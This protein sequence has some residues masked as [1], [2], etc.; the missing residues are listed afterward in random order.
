[1]NN[2]NL[3]YVPKGKKFQSAVSFFHDVL[4]ISRNLT[5]CPANL[6]P[7]YFLILFPVPSPRPIPRS[8]PLSP[9]LP[10]SR[11]ISFSPGPLLVRHRFLRAP[12]TARE[13][14]ETSGSHFRGAAII[15]VTA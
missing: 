10:R 1:M 14:R 6:T 3:H 8:L 5:G 4:Q 12:D 2:I 13:L 11:P 7:P 9:L 15:Y